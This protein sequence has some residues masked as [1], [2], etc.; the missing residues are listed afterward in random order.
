MALHRR[1]GFASV[2]VAFGRFKFGRW[3]DVPLMQ[4][5]L[6][7]G[8]RRPPDDFIAAKSAR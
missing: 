1:F 8:E 4:R 2:G 7:V 3:V 6:G 5:A